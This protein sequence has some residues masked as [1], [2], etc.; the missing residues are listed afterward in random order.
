MTQINAGTGTGARIVRES[1]RVTAMQRRTDERTAKTGAALLALLL[2]LVAVLS[3]G[4][5]PARAAPSPPP[6][7]GA[8]VISLRAPLPASVP[9]TPCRGD[10][11]PGAAVTCGGPGCAS[12][13]AS[14]IV[15]APVPPAPLSRRPLR[16]V[17]TFQ[18]LPGGLSHNPIVPPPR[19][20]A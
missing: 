19:H 13:S 6:A 20:T 3:W 16:F 17:I 11:C 5:V 18:L 14:A 10:G 8:V 2:V 9:V 4:G 12:V 15:A 1:G 7:I